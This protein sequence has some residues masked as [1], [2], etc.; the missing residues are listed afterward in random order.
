MNYGFGYFG[1]GYVGGEWAG[2]TFR[3]NSAVTRVDERRIH[4]YYVDRSVV[5]SRYVRTR[6]RI[7]YDGGAHGL[8]LRPTGGE[9]VAAHEHHIGLTSVQAQHVRL[10]A[11][12]HTLRASV[13]HGRPARA[14]VARPFAATATHAHAMQAHSTYH[15]PAAHHAYHA[16]SAQH[17]Y[18]A[19]A[20]QHAYHGP[21]VQHAYHAQAQHMYHAS[22]G[23]ASHGRSGG[24][25][26][27][28]GDTH[29]HQ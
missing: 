7:S 10:A 16:P 8:H 4:S 21:A 23:H 25:S 28:G 13:N 29:K 27:G 5:S 9:L 20:V 3:Y 6:T 24:G 11:H 2:D 22:S 1:V 19:P 17:V 18:H 26:H 15:A 14:A 12:D